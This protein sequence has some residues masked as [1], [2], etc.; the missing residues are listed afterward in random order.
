MSTY[1]EVTQ[2]QSAPRTPGK[3]TAAFVL[4]LVG[5]VLIPL[6]PSVLAIVL[7]GGA[8]REIDGSGGSL[9]GRG[10]ATAGVVLG[11]VALAIWALFIVAIVAL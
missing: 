11:W 6:I 3:A 8:K 9:S 5:L 2:S 7:G 1:G 4:G 10:L